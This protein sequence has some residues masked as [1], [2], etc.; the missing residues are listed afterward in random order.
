MGMAASQARLLTITARLA[1][2]ELRSQTIN[3][4]K[5]RLASQTSQVS[6]EYVSA[7]NNAQ[8]MFTNSNYDGLSQTQLLTFNS[9]TQYSPYNTQYGLVNASGLALV[10]EE[11][12]MIFEANKGSLEG[13]LSAHGLEWETTFFEEDVNPNLSA[14]LTEFYGTG[15]NN[16]G[17][18]F[19]GKSN[20][21]LKKM[22]LDS[23]TDDSSVAFF[24]YQTAAYNYYS[25]I[26]MMYENTVPALRNDLFGDSSSGINEQTVADAIKALGNATSVK[27]ELLVGDKSGY[28]G[29]IADTKDNGAKFSINYLTTAPH[30][31][32]YADAAN[33]LKAL[34]SSLTD[35]TISRTLSGTGAP[36]IGAQATGFED[37]M[38]SLSSETALGD[39]TYT[40]MDGSTGTKAN[41]NG[42]KYTFGG[43]PSFTLTIDEYT[44]GP[45]HK[46]YKDNQT[47]SNVSDPSNPSATYV[48][49]AGNTVSKYSLIRSYYNT[50][51]ITGP[52]TTL[53]VGSSSTY[54]DYTYNGSS[55]PATISTST[56]IST[57]R[58]NTTAQMQNIAN[59]ISAICKGETETLPDGS[60][61]VEPDME[62]VYRYININETL[63]GTPTYQ[64]AR[65]PLKYPTTSSHNKNEGYEALASMYFG[66]L[67]NS[68]GVFDA[69][70]YAEGDGSGSPTLAEYRDAKQYFEDTYGITNIPST[71][72]LVNIDKMMTK[73]DRTKFTTALNSDPTTALGSVVRSYATQKMLEVLGEPK[74][75][76]VDHNDS[77]HNE[78]A[79]SKAQWYTNLY[80]RMQKGYK[81]LENGLASSSDWLEYA[82]ETG[83]VTMEQVDRSYNWIGM[84]YKSCANITE[85]TDTSAMVAKAEAKYN[86][87]MNDIKQKDSMYDLQL[88]N[89]DTEHS[90]L[91]TEYDVI[92]GVLSKN[93]DRT[94]KFDQSA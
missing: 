94:M 85:N 13:F 33:D 75:C 86:R 21:D 62:V 59:N 67:L 64:L 11:D 27:Q 91:Q 17:Y 38:S 6:D 39:L 66:Y 50:S 81:V 55:F 90:S 15:A 71:D 78:N 32:L 69:N 10:S 25:Q 41:G 48:D 79:D 14:T 60:T 18:M 1:D 3:N 37:E 5:M 52:K 40:Q 22:Y 31:Y 20:D 23:L 29:I 28:T 74:Y 24:N 73:G 92:K 76:W 93:I 44:L 53:N 89:I 49:S 58:S 87:A 82:F 30:N 43:D 83:L 26:I 70:A 8:L 65:I 61:V 2:N 72:C 4:A 34:V 47:G 56:Y 36:S 12:A 45:E 16:I 7:L 84:D 80:D 46:L 54:T 88:K 77:L 68:P 9:L 42:Y 63:G 35:A 19:S 57:F 51:E